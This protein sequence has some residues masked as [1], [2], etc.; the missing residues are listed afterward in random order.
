MF[1]QKVK[2]ENDKLNVEQPSFGN[3]LKYLKKGSYLMI[4]TKVDEEKNV[5]E[6]QK[7]YRVILKQ[8]SIDTGNDPSEMHDICKDQV[9]SQMKI[10]STTDLDAAKW[11][12][13]FE[14][15]RE[16]SLENFDFIF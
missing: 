16:W 7:L 12:E 8:M 9:L 10:G 1:I 14:R 5:R 15:L 6:W 3:A 4:L 11:A 2:I 13:Y